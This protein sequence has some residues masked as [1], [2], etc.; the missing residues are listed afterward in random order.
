MEFQEMDFY[1]FYLDYL[2][3][4]DYENT[5]VRVADNGRDYKELSMKQLKEDINKLRDET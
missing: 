1:K 2:S 3:N 5:L 4:K